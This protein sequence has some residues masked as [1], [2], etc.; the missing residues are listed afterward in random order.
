MGKVKKEKLLKSEK[1]VTVDGS[2]N[3]VSIKFP[4]RFEIGLGPSA[5]DFEKGLQVYG[6]IS[7]SGSLLAKASGYISFGDVPGTGGY[8]FRDNNGTLQYRNSPNGQLAEWLSFSSTGNPAGSDTQVQFNDGGSAF[9]G[10][11]E[12]V[13][14]KTSNTLAIGSTSLSG[15]S[16]I[17]KVYDTISGSIHHTAAG[18]SYIVG[19]SNVIVASASNG[20]ITI[21]SQ[22]SGGSLTVVSQSVSVSN[23]TTIAASDGW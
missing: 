11:T 2:G 17:V 9:G 15:D 16:G 18:K 7:I 5:P 1:L 14:N 19:G 12:F 4:N 8:G 6:N 3:V 22:G 23:V 13:W 20:Q 10:D 21:S